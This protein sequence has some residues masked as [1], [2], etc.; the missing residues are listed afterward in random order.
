M[1]SVGPV[2]QKAPRLY[3]VSKV[4]GNEVQLPPKVVGEGYW[5]P[6]P[7]GLYPREPVKSRLRRV[8]EV[9]ATLA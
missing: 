6:R 4:K 7:R 5:P 9:A 3:A 1:A 2:V 8:L